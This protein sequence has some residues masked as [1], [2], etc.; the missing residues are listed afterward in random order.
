[1]KYSIT[2]E[3]FK[4]KVMEAEVNKTFQIAEDFPFCSFIIDDANK[5]DP[6]NEGAFSWTADHNYNVSKNVGYV[7][8]LKSSNYIKVF[9][10]VAGAKRNLIKYFSYL[11]N[12]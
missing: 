12:N 2:F 8:P 6:D 11:F 10:T 3:Q 4:A 1:M 9:K 5:D 7:M